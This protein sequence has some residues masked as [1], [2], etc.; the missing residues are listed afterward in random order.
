MAG[1]KQDKDPKYTFVINSDVSLVLRRMRDVPM[2]KPRLG[3]LRSETAQ[4]ETQWE[5][6][7]HVEGKKM[8][9]FAG[10]D[11]YTR[12]GVSVWE[13]AVLALHFH[14][15]TMDNAI[16]EH[17]D[18]E[19]MTTPQFRWFLDTARKLRNDVDSVSMIGQIPGVYMVSEGGYETHFRTDGWPVA[20]DAYNE[21]SEDTAR[22]AAAQMD[23][24]DPAGEAPVTYPN[25]ENSPFG[26]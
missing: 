14:M 11:L 26:G 4:L 19:S 2:D 22:L 1:K 10:T 16:P 5:Y 7:I 18:T 25:I 21:L 17:F 3:V 8:P 20:P 13:S 15:P 23:Y 12:T 6:A 24:T 9:L